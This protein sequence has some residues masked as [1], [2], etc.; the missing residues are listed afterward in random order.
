VD[1]NGALSCEEWQER[2]PPLW[3]QST[4]QLCEAVLTKAHND[5]APEPNWHTECWNKKGDMTAFCFMP[6]GTPATVAV[7]LGQARSRE[8]LCATLCKLKVPPALMEFAQAA[9]VLIADRLPEVMPYNVMS[10]A[11]PALYVDRCS[12]CWT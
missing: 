7:A 11:K 1:R 4:N 10:R 6:G 2:D 9:I 3:V 5:R 12:I 8:S